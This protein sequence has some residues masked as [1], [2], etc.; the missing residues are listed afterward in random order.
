MV[1]A[2]RIER[3]VAL[4]KL[5]A[6]HPYRLFSFSYFCKKFDIAKS[7]LSEDVLAVKTGLELHG[8]GKVETVS[9]AAGGVRF[10]PCHLTEDDNAF[11]QELAIRLSSPERILPGGMLYTTDILCHPETVV[12]LGEIFMN[13]LQ[14]LSPDCIMT[15]ETSGIPLAMQVA[16]AFNV[17]LVIARH[18]SDITEGSTVNINYVSG[19]TKTIQNMA[20]PKRALKPNSRVL[21]IDDVMKGGGTAKG[22]E[23]LAHEV[24]VQVVGKAFL[25]STAK[26]ER[27]L[28]DD[29]IA[30][31][32]LHP[33]DEDKQQIQIDINNKKGFFKNE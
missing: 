11:L 22:I 25:I 20:M 2:K 5:L 7:T 27:K 18:T 14:S 17:P 12:R 13:R 30:F 15:V 33:L 9:G 28:V 26:P 3:V 24:G 21:I 4:T 6:D 32:T 1:K 19:S 16:R 29:Y 31:F 23:A 8:L 10:I